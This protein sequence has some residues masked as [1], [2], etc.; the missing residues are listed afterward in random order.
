MVRIGDRFQV[1]VVEDHGAMRK[2]GNYTLAYI[3]NLVS[4]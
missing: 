1:D 4:S 3:V 2:Y